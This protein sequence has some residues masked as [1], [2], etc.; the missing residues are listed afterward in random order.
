MID[1]NMQIVPEK[2]NTANLMYDE[3]TEHTS[4]SLT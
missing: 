2:S 3:L 1:D 4:C